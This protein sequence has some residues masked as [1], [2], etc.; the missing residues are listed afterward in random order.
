MRTKRVDIEMKTSQ[1]WFE[2]IPED[3]GFIILKPNGWDKRDYQFSFHEE[4]ITK[5]HFLMRI[6]YS[7]CIHRCGLNLSETEWAQSE[8]NG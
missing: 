5:S 2:D 1:E 8:T 7:V 4:L 3:Y 6:Q